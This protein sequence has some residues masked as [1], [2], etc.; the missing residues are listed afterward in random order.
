MECPQPLICKSAI[1]FTQK[2]AAL[3]SAPKK[4]QI[5]S[6]NGLFWPELKSHSLSLHKSEKLEQVALDVLSFIKAN[7]ENSHQNIGTNCRNVS[8][9]ISKL[10]K[11]PTTLKDF[12]SWVQ[13]VLENQIKAQTRRNLDEQKESIESTRKENFR[14]MSEE[15]E[16]ELSK[17]NIKIIQ[18][19]E[20][21]AEGQ[22][23]I[24]R[25][26]ETIKKLEET[27]ALYYDTVLFASQSNIVPT[28]L[29]KLA[30][31]SY[32]SAYIETGMKKQNLKD[33]PKLKL[34]PN[35]KHAFDFQEFSQKT[36]KYFLS[37]VERPEIINDIEDFI[38]LCSLRKFALFISD[39]KLAD[40]CGENIL[41]FTIDTGFV[42]DVLTADQAPLEDALIQGAIQ[43]ASERF[44]EIAKHQLFHSVQHTHLVEIIRGDDLD[45]LSEYDLLEKLYQWCGKTY[46]LLN[47][48]LKNG[49]LI[50]QVR[51]EFFENRDVLKL[52]EMKLINSTEVTNALKRKEQFSIKPR[53]TRPAFS[54]ESTLE[55]K[56]TV[57][58]RFEN[59][60]EAELV[61][62]VFRWFDHPLCIVFS[63]TNDP[64]SFFIGVTGAEER[65]H[66]EKFQ[67]NIRIG[68]S[69][70]ALA[71]G[72]TRC[73]LDKP[74]KNQFKK[75]FLSSHLSSGIDG[76]EY[77][78]IEVV[79]LN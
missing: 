7:Q 14:R 43:Y 44:S 59:I 6:E 63:Y 2:L 24:K 20:I 60:Q 58:W 78:E 11:N 36:L 77:L 56:T 65:D 5:V 79:F 32:F 26:V 57:K 31:T 49:S 53:L 72:N 17:R 13:S 21:I 30:N 41:T 67:Y 38:A 48:K 74:S 37:Y 10:T 64:D 19:E 8:I 40:L 16:S 12:D 76:K 34:Y 51:L 73:A 42:M 1:E 62:P 9:I 4:I 66:Y 28:R 22:E 54:A 3:A 39:Q 33:R 25:L 71:K 45:I 70:P 68:N 23:E 50:D 27:Q 47:Q 69:A 18:L 15:T 29:E 55:G 52:Q 75:K 35:W 46:D 61:S